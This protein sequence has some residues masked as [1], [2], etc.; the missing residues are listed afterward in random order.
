MKKLLLFFSI[1]LVG[2]A[3]AQSTHTAKQ[4]DTPY[5]ISKMYNLT[6][7]DLYKL[8]PNLKDG[9]LNIGDKISVAKGVSAS[10]STAKQTAEIVLQP[11]QTI[12]GITKQYKIS[13][14][15]LRK[16]NPDLD[17]KTKV[18]DRITLPMDKI[19][20]YGNG[21][22]LATDDDLEEEIPNVQEFVQIEGPTYSTTSV[23]DDF[24][25]Y[26]V[27]DGDTTFGIIN[28]FNITIDE[29]IDLNPQISNGLK[30]GMVLKIKKLPASYVKKSGNTLNVVFMLPL[31]YENG[32]SKY[33]DMSLEFMMGAKLSLERNAKNG[34][35]LNVKIV[36]AG[37]DTTF[38]KS[39]SQ[40][41][42]D[43]TDL[44]IGPFFKSSLM[45]VLEY[46]KLNKIPVVSPFAN[47]KDLHSYD[48]LIV[49]ETDEQIYADKVAEEVLKTYSNQKIY[50]VASDDK[51]FADSI[52]STI[53]NQA[54]NAEVIIIAS[55]SELKLDTN[56]MTGQAAPIIAV[57][58]D[59]RTSEGT[60][61]ANKLLELS[62]KTTG[63]KAFSMYYSS[64]FDAKQENLRQVNLVYLIDTKINME[65]SFEKEILKDYKDKFCKTPGKY[66]V[67]GFDVTN[68]MLS[69]E[70]SKGEIFKQISKA[71]TQLATKFDFVR[72]NGNGAY[73][74][75]GYR[76]VRL[77]P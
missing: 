8:N 3:S 48:N 60:A 64:V 57:L 29:L 77:I 58:A 42:K 43:N 16:L 24:L 65:G 41:D 70:N 36:D 47:S 51:G 50:I 17:N 30:A 4:G 52:K 61:F 10:N 73:L 56:M 45:E 39:L 21:Q 27:Q 67:V 35:K 18:G 31:G 33:R 20:K 6:L 2:F 23:K 22:P 49:I 53:L 44:I 54:K 11:K 74:N 71:Q 40:I 66:A 62:S 14:A 25:Y 13:E 59:N 7:E 12:Y 55:S 32:D 34:Q 28:K 15:D 75:T 69:R 72:T 38:K 19:S 26:T 37:N 68:D 1:L 9:V 76:V 46:V 63:I 5:G